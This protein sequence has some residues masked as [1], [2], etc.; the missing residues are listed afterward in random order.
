MYSFLF[1]K[2]FSKNKIKNKKKENIKIKE[3]DKW[4]A[5]MF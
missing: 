4:A 5:L 3:R 2:S 1:Y